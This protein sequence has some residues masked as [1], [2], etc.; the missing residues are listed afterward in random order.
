MEGR[1]IQ[2][3]EAMTTDKQRQTLQDASDDEKFII[4]L[5]LACKV[6]NRF[7]DDIPSDGFALWK[8]Q[9]LR[10]VIAELPPDR[11]PPFTRK[12]QDGILETQAAMDRLQ[13]ELDRLHG[14]SEQF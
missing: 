11:L 9:Q 14:Q 2:H 6:V 8:F 12:I 3:M 13:S 1:R 4:A 7:I 5:D 10:E